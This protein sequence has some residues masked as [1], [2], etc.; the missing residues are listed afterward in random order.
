MQEPGTGQDAAGDAMHRDISMEWDEEWDQQEMDRD[1]CPKE[2]ASG[3]KL[4]GVLRRGRI[5]L[6]PQGQLGTGFS[7]EW[8]CCHPPHRDVLPPPSAGK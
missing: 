6:C 3:R 8:L 5:D 1:M 7:R 2:L 4:Q